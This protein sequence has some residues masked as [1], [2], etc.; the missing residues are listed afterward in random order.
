MDL[1]A[2]CSFLTF[3]AI[4]ARPVERIP[5]KLA[6]C[7]P[8][9]LLQRQQIKVCCIDDSGGIVRQFAFST[10]GHHPAEFNGPSQWRCRLQRLPPFLSGAA[11]RSLRDLRR[12]RTSRSRT[13]K[14]CSRDH[15]DTLQRQTFIDHGSKRQ[16]L[17]ERRIT[18]KKRLLDRVSSVLR[19][20]L[21]GLHRDRCSRRNPIL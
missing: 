15:R 19:P 16:F 14:V 21:A 11:P 9:V 20:P 1:I 18:G 10:Q 8:T 12:L 7:H 13:R 17:L 6:Y 2:D 3:W 5:T 4:E